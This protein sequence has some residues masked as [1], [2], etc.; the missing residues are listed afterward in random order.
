[1]GCLGCVGSLVSASEPPARWVND[2]DGGA[3]CW[4]GGLTPSESLAGLPLM[5]SF[6]GED[7]SL[8]TAR[9]VWTISRTMDSMSP[10]VKGSALLSDCVPS[11]LL[12]CVRRGRFARVTLLVAAL[13]DGV[14]DAALISLVLLLC[15]VTPAPEAVLFFPLG[16]TTDQFKDVYVIKKDSVTL[17]YK[18]MLVLLMQHAKGSA[19]ALVIPNDAYLAEAPP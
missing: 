12:F 6:R 17:S 13:S 7:D 8:A 9:V 11:G 4:S 16:I 18:H 5:V 10:R 14:V 15:A 2:V 19:H 3:L 1:M